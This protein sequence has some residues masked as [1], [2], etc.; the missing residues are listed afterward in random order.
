M[1]SDPARPLVRICTTGRDETTETM[2]FARVASRLG[3]FRLP[4]GAAMSP[5]EKK[6][7][8]WPVCATL[9]SVLL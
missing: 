8:A 4:S 7:P 3:G 5:G 1:S 2:L 6:M 9:A